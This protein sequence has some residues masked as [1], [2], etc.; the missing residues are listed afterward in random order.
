[1]QKQ[2]MPPLRSPLGRSPHHCS[3][4][5]FEKRPSPHQNYKKGNW[6]PSPK[7]G[8]GIRAPL[9]GAG[10]GNAPRVLLLSS[11]KRKEKKVFFLEG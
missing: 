11:L 4:D 9:K 3:V 8:A 7:K 6:L 5:F 1:L 2:G 10:I